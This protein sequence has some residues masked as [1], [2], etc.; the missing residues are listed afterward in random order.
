MYAEETRYDVTVTQ[1]RYDVVLFDVPIVE[2]CKGH[3]TLWVIYAQFSKD[4][5][6]ALKL[7][8]LFYY[9]EGYSWMSYEG[10][11]IKIS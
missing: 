4:Q 7:L 1:Q 9:G 6:S 3:M 2:M 11:S 10:I 5:N 8:L